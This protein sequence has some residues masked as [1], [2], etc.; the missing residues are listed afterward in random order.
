MGKERL[1]RKDGGNKKGKG[2]KKEFL[3][4][5]NKYQRE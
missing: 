1:G 2:R 4:G 5:K 3:K